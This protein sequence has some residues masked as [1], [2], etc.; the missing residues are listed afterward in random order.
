MTPRIPARSAQYSYTV[1]AG[2][3]VRSDP[4]TILNIQLVLSTTINYS[5]FSFVTLN[6]DNNGTPVDVEGTSVP[7]T[8]NIGLRQYDGFDRVAKPDAGQSESFTASRAGS[9]PTR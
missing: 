6:T 4:I 7:T 5:G 9:G 3:I 2:S 8:I 1:N